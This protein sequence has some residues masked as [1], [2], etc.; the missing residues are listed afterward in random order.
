MLKEFKQFVMQGNVLDLAI[1]IIIGA[2]FG[3]V[4]TSLVTDIL[5]PPIGL[6]LGKVD[7]SNLFITLSGDK[8]NTV[9]EA[10]AGGAVTINYGNFL[11]TVV[12]FVIVAFCIFMIVKQI[13]RFRRN[14]PSAAVVESPEEKVLVEIRDILKAK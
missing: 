14:A 1:G 9:A 3:A 2:A 4:V 10:Q 5:M 8:F 6:A 13:N 7:F 11:N 12:T